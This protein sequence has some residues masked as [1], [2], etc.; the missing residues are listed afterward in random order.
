MAAQ[1]NYSPIRHPRYI[2]HAKGYQPY[3][4]PMRQPRQI[5]HPKAAQVYYSPQGSPGILFTL[6]QPR[7]I[8][9]AEA[10]QAYYSPIRLL[11]RRYALVLLKVTNSSFEIYT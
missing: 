5:I 10:A 7:H 6:W 9:H 8:I 11:G 2:I 1:A 3:Y 4:S